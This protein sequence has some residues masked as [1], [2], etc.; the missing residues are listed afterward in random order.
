MPIPV[1]TG[2]VISGA[3]ARLFIDGQV[4]GYAT[5]IDVTREIQY[6]PIRVL[7]NIEV[8]EFVPIGYECST[9]A[10]RVRIV[11]GS[12][13]GPDL[14]I[15]PQVGKTPEDHLR[16]ILDRSEGY[17]IQVDDRIANQ[18]VALLLGAVA[19]RDSWSLDA[20]GIVGENIDFLAIKVAD[21]LGFV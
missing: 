5:G 7:D 17:D 19:Q 21:E 12:L 14:A 15:W 8:S 13:S 20:R 9:S 6:E 10:R 18:T 1:P 4:V 2:N 3:R 11:P 16:S